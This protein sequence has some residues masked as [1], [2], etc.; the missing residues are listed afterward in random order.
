MLDRSAVNIAK[1][2]LE[3]VAEKARSGEKNF[4]LG[5]GFNKPHVSLI[6][7]QKYYELYPGTNIVRG[8]REQVNQNR[9]K[10]VHIP[11]LC[12]VKCSLF[13][14]PVATEEGET[15]LA[16]P[17]WHRP[18]FRPGSGI[19]N[20]TSVNGTWNMLPTET[21]RHFRQVRAI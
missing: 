8:R 9:E 4:F 11:L 5:F 1:E 21:L 17:L 2:F 18:L 15:F 19:I 13:S 12:A 14:I 16:E 7:P 6:C 20:G 3:R 10:R